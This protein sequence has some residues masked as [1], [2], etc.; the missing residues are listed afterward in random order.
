MLPA[1]DS[2]SVIHSV[3][4][5]CRVPIIVGS[6]LEKLIARALL[7]NSSTSAKGPAH[8]VSTNSA[9]CMSG[10]NFK[11]ARKGYP[12]GTTNR[13]PLWSPYNHTTIT[14]P[15]PMGIIQAPILRVPVRQPT[16]Q[17]LRRE[18]QVGS[19]MLHL[20]LRRLRVS[21]YRLYLRPSLAADLWAIP[22]L[23]RVVGVVAAKL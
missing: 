22:I 19:R 4:K 12:E 1:V 11:L 15:N 20:C 16:L 13:I 18:A 8:L 9:S 17:L 14:P 3:S 2:G 5:G 6:W 7:L 23:I 21:S 10:L